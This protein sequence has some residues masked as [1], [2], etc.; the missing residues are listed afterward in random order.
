MKVAV[1]LYTLRNELAKDFEGVLRQVAKLG[2][3]GVEFAGFY[4]IP[5]NQM[6]NL[7]AEL[8]LIAV[9]SHTGLDLLEN[10][11]EEVVSYNQTIGNKNIVVPWTSMKTVEELKEISEKLLK[12]EKELAKRG[13]VLHY[14]NHAHEFA[15]YSNEYLLDLLYQKVPNMYAEVDTHWVQRAGV[16]PVEYVKKYQG[17]N[18]LVHLKDLVMNNGQ[19]EF[20]PLGKGIMDLKGIVNQARENKVEAVIVENDQPKNGGIEDITISIKYIK[21]A[22]L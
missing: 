20:A 4:N 1:Q 10:H 8:N 6:K 2:Y 17:R 5:A 22:L 12:I 19:M 13:L 16:N 15:R 3:D 11:F 21:E 7:L 9:G 18:T 14:H